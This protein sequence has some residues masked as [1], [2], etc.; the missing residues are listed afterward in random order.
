[1]FLARTRLRTQFSRQHRAI[2][3]GTR[4]VLS[5][6]VRITIRV[7]ASTSSRASEEASSLTPHPCRRQWHAVSCVHVRRLRA[8]RRRNID[9]TAGKSAH[10]TRPD[11]TQRKATQNATQCGATR[12]DAANSHLFNATPRMLLG[13]PHTRISDTERP[14]LFKSR[15]RA[16]QS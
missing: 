1:M 10:E 6:P 11:A 13:G 12:R 8:P 3:Y 14:W 15:S 16:G 2:R 7:R 4:S 9:L 5:L